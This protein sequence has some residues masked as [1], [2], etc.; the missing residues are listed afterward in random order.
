[1]ARPSPRMEALGR[2]GLVLSEINPNILATAY[3]LISSV[4][5]WIAFYLTPFSS[6]ILEPFHAAPSWSSL[7]FAA[8]FTLSCHVIGLFDP[9]HE[10]RIGI[11]LVKVALAGMIGCLATVFLTSLVL[12]QQIGR[13][14]L[15]TG[16]AL[17]TVSTIV[18]QKLVWVATQNYRPHLVLVGTIDF[19][20]QAR[21]FLL[22]QPRPVEVRL[23]PVEFFSGD[24]GSLG[25]MELPPDRLIN[26]ISSSNT[27]KIVYQPR[28]FESLEK[29]L[30]RAL[31]SG[32]PAQSY[33]DYVEEHYGRMLPEEL[34]G[35]WLMSGS[36][37][38]R[39]NL[40]LL[41]KRG[42][43]ITVSL[44]GLLLASPI[45]ALVA[46][47]IWIEDRG[48]VFYKQTRLGEFGK[49]FQI[50][51]LRSMKVN[52]EQTGIQWA[53]ENDPRVTRLGR[54]L[55]LTRIDEFPQFLNILRDEMSL[56]GPRP[57]RPEFVEKL[58]KNIEHYQFRH[59]LKPGLSGW[60]QINF[61]YGS[62]EE[63]AASKLTYDLYYIKRASLILDLQI[64]LR[65]IG[66]FCKGSR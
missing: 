32:I 22:H 45:I 24:S 28:I 34:P 40:F 55:R 57:E 37:G 9:V 65:T 21:N 48:P 12:F 31:Q 16:W 6:R 17:T 52:A 54:F 43:D 56:I 30:F 7:I 20:N 29:A 59:L 53:T 25:G 42:V 49:P 35:S 27:S 5:F 11:V 66:A 60:A 8:S 50:L 26:L 44:V 38:A 23:C 19:C 18:L 51:K 2:V 47:A 62:S 33:P 36:F 58:S 46:A 1:M 3:F 15:V 10:R 64:A 4:C 41:L 63:D 39:R 13:I 14:I 61:T